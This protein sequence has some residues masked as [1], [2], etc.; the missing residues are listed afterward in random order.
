MAKYSNSL[1]VIRARLSSKVGDLITGTPDS[2]SSTTIVDTMLREAD[3][4]YNKHRYKC[5]IYDGTNEGE[6]REVSDWVQSS[7]TLTLAPSYTAA[8]D[9]TSLYELHKIFFADDLL[10]AINQAIDFSARIP[11]LFDVRD[12]TTS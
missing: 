3:D 11:Y 5:Y 8:I 9:T 7:N 12:Q 1:A 2:G 10:K 4:Y 6:E